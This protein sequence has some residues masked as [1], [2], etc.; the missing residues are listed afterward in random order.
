[1]LLLIFI[2]T[3]PFFFLH[4][5]SHVLF[6][7]VCEYVAFMNGIKCSLH[8]FS[9]IDFVLI[10]FLCFFIY[11]TILFATTATE[12]QWTGEKCGQVFDMSR[13]SPTFVCWNIDILFF[14]RY[15][16]W[17]CFFFSSLRFWVYIEICA[18]HLFGI[19]SNVPH[20]YHLL[21]LCPS[22]TIRMYLF[23]LCIFSSA[24]NDFEKFMEEIKIIS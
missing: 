22:I 23:F 11:R 12:K 20:S 7:F 9:T 18:K 19:D 8:F 15:F 6:L 16:C 4:P 10:L 24:R 2:L 21:H 5:V 3:A 17:N 14:C 1:M 13:S